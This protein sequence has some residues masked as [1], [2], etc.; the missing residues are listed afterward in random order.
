MVRQSREPDTRL[1][2]GAFDAVGIVQHGD[3]VEVTDLAEQFASPVDHRLHEVVADLSRLLHALFDGLFLVAY[4]FHV[5]G[6][7]K[8]SHS[9]LLVS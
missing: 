5:N 3:A 9:D 1:L 2:A 8:L 4:E 6:D 7:A